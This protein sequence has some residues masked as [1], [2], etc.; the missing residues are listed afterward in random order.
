MCTRFDLNT[1]SGIIASQKNA[2]FKKQEKF[3]QKQKVNNKSTIN[4]AY[5]S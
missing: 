5:L 4:G 2:K 3:V 1:A